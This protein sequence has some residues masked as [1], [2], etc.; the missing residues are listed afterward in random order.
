MASRGREERVDRM[1]QILRQR[2]IHDSRVLDAMRTVPRDR[3]VPPDLEEQA[4]D[5]AALPVGCGQTISQPLIVAWM[6]ELLELTG[7]ETVLEIGTGTGYQT[8]ILA[9]LSRRVISME[10]IAELSTTAA[11]RLEKFA[12]SNVELVVGDGTL[13]W[14]AEAPY[15]AILAAAGTPQMPPPLYE[16]LR[17]GGRLVLPIGD[18]SAQ[19]M[20]RIWKTAEGP[21]IERLGGCR[22]VPLIGKAGWPDH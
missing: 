16:Q 5:D 3:F 7:D 6:T 8:A 21:R 4:Y 9:M 19:E 20:H 22:F 18:A 2:G 1:L 11:R 17:M 14:A 12:I 13:G 10:R 15:D